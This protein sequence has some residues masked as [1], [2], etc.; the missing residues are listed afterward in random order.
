MSIKF[1][2]QGTYNIAVMAEDD[3]GAY[4]DW[5]YLEVTMPVNQQIKYY[6]F[7]LIQKM[8]E[9]FPKLRQMLGV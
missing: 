6:G 2:V 1:D 8:L 9:L 7:P 4:S 5:A 3:R